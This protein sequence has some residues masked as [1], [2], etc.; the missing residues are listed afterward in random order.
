MKKTEADIRY[1]V[2]SELFPAAPSKSQK[3]TLSII[4]GAIKCYGTYGIEGATYEKIAKF[5]KVSRPL[6]QHYFKSREALFELTVKYI[7]VQFQQLVV[8]SMKKETGVRDQ[9]EAYIRSTF[10]W[11][12]KYPHHGRVWILFYFE[13]SVNKK[14]KALNT[15]L[16][17]LGRARIQALIEAGNQQGVFKCAK[18]ADS[19]YTIQTMITGALVSVGTETHPGSTRDFAQRIVDD[20]MT[21]LGATASALVAASNR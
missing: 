19:A 3:T 4:E 14:M 13:C 7:R 9:L 5:A 10:T 1:A 16:V 18:A 15:E 17:Q 8:D 2:L 12:E 11:A 21:R 20:C 6:V